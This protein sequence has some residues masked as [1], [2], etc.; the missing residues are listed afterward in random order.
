MQAKGW[1]LKMLIWGKKQN[2]GVKYNIEM[3]VIYS[4]C[5]VFLVNLLS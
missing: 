5:V 1:G 2:S 4:I 3:N